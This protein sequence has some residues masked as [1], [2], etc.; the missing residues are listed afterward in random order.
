MTS[1]KRAYW[2]SIAEEW[3]TEQRHLL[4]RR[5]SD[6]VNSKLLRRWLPARKV[7]RLL[8]TD[9]FD[10]VVSQG[11]YS[12]LSDHSE[13]FVG[14]D[15]SAGIVDAANRHYPKLELHAADVNNALDE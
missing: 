2:D 7:T 10:E 4:W 15:L 1:T 14:V 6:A 8:K 13:N 3:M 11:L 9:L 5:H 12:L